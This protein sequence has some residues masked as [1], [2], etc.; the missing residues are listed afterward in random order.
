M[1]PETFIKKYALRLTLQITL[2]VSVLTL[3]GSSLVP[4]AN[5]T[6]TQNTEILS[7]GRRE[8]RG[9]LFSSF[10]ARKKSSIQIFLLYSIDELLSAFATALDTK[11]IFN[12]KVIQSFSPIRSKQLIHHAARYNLSDLTFPSKG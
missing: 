8:K 12:A 4:V 2:L 11:V 1:N 9:I 3:S 7:T 10:I 5:H 6:N